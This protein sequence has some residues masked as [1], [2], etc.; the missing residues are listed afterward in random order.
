MLSLASQDILLIFVLH[1][2]IISYTGEFISNLFHFF[3]YKCK[4]LHVAVTSVYELV[5]IGNKITCISLFCGGFR[6]S[7]LFSRS[8]L[9]TPSPSPDPEESS[10]RRS[11][12]FI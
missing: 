9:P 10:R 12:L 3:T 4:R 11:F 1:K 8:Q 5:Q 7:N 6:M 2:R